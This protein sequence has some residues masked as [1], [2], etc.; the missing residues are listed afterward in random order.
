[1]PDLHV[2]SQIA[3]P[4]GCCGSFPIAAA[5]TVP[6]PK[7]DFSQRAHASTTYSD[8]VK[9]SCLCNHNS[10]TL[11]RMVS[12]MTPEALI[13]LESSAFMLMASYR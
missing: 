4:I 7:Q 5:D 3:Q 10:G 6:H 1:M 2:Y 13:G 9:V 11:S 12:T 8:E